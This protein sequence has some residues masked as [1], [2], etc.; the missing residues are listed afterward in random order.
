MK[1]S[2]SS[3]RRSIRLLVGD[4]LFLFDLLRALAALVGQLQLF[5]L[6]SPQSPEPVPLGF[7]FGLHPSAPGLLLLHQIAVRGIHRHLA[8]LLQ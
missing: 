4:A 3:K 1:R 2:W 6:A 7:Q 5:L 8:L